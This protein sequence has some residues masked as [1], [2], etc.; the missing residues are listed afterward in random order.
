MCTM[1]VSNR[2][3]WEEVLKQ[4]YKGCQHK[5]HDWIEFTQCEGVECFV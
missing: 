4:E 2:E 5:L 3:D 1:G